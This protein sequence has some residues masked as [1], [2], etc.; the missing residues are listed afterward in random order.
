LWDKRKYQ[1]KKT[2]KYLARII[3]E[4]DDDLPA[5]E[6]QI[7]KARQVW[8]RINKITGTRSCKYTCIHG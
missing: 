1:E 6:T 4:T 8:G 5:A 7:N 2:F 3:N